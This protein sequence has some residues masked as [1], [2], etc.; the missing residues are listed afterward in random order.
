MKRV[1][2]K[3]SFLLP[4]S[5]KVKHSK[6]KGNGVFAINDIKSGEII[7]RSPV[8][9]IPPEDGNMIAF[10]DLASYVYSDGAE[11]EVLALGYA[12][13]YNHSHNPNA[14][15][16]VSKKAIV[17]FATSDIKAGEEVFIDYGWDEYPWEKQTSKE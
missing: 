2:I 7:E 11:G 10:T 15:Y 13:L 14:D 17:V 8:I 6:D 9:H 3:G 12:S 5:V 16:V 1:G 4:S